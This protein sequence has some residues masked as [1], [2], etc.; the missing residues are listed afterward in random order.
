MAEFYPVRLTQ[1]GI[2]LM[3][4]VQTGEELRFTYARMGDG[5]IGQTPNPTDLINVI[6]EIEI[7]DP[8]IVDGGW[9]RFEFVMDNV[10]QG[11]WFRELG[12]YAMDPD[13]GEILYAFTFPKDI[14]VPGGG[15][16]PGADWVPP[17]GSSSPWK[18]RF[19]IF[20]MVGNATNV[21]AFISEGNYVTMDDLAVRLPIISVER[22]A[23]LA[24]AIWGQIVQT[25]PIPGSGGLSEHDIQFQHKRGD[26]EYDAFTPLWSFIGSDNK[27]YW[28]R[29]GVSPT[30]GARITYWEAI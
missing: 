16:A 8:T 19:S 26:G 21:T 3:S 22:P 15:F 5:N 25:R 18:P 27:K 14:P 24:G 20:V 1:K 17:I 13:E 11:F 10:D 2:L 30:F 12:I 23:Q 6:K 7:T 9:V 29:W 4:K 28:A